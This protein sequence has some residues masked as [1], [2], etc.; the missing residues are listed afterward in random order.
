MHTVIVQLVLYKHLLSLIGQC[1]IITA[2]IYLTPPML[3]PGV[4]I[5]GRLIF[6]VLIV[7][8]LALL[9]TFLIK[10]CQNILLYLLYYVL[11][12]GVVNFFNTTLRIYVVL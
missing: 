1:E 10:H 6:V 2:P 9:K 12:V 7:Q 3:F 11:F 8:Y 4:S 5:C